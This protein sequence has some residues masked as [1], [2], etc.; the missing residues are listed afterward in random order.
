MKDDIVPLSQPVIAAGGKIIN[1]L[2]IGKGMRVAVPMIAVNLSSALW[3]DDAFQFRPERWLEGVPSRA[4]EVTGYRHLLSF[5][6]GPKVF[7]TYPATMLY[8]TKSLTQMP[9]SQLCGGQY[10]SFAG[11]TRA[12]IPLRVSQWATHSDWHRL[13]CLD[14]SESRRRVRMLCACLY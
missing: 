8:R 14:S 10:E 1:H 7:V 9:G 11:C 13:D 2:Q 6:D 3:G 5:I 12:Q 4:Q